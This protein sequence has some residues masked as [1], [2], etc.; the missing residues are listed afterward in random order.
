MANYATLKAAIAS[1]IKQNGNNEITGNL[2]QAQL[3][4]MINSLGA[5]YQYAGIATPAMNPGTPDPKVFY[6]ASTAG[7]YVNFGGLVLADGEIAILK[8]NGA[9]SKDSTGAASLEKLNQ[10]G[11]QTKFH[12]NI[13]LGYEDIRIHAQYNSSGEYAETEYR[14]LSDFIPVTYGDVILVDLDQGT[15]Q[16]SIAAFDSS[17]NIILQNSKTGL[18]SGYY[19]VPQ[20]V[21]FLRFGCFINTSPI[22]RK[23]E[24][25]DSLAICYSRTPII[26]NNNTKKLIIKSDLIV[27]QRG[28]SW[29]LQP[30][31]IPFEW[32]AA[33]SSLVRVVYDYDAQKIKFEY[34]TNNTSTYP[35][36]ATLFVLGTD[37]SNREVTFV[38]SSSV[39]TTI[40]GGTIIN[41]KTY[42]GEK[43]QTNF[44]ERGQ[45][46]TLQ[47]ARNHQSFASYNNIGVFVN[48]GV[49]INGNTDETAV[50]ASVHNLQTGALLG[51][52]LL[53]YG[54]N[55]IPH[56]NVVTFG[57]EFFSADSVLPLLYVSQWNGGKK[58][59]VYDITNNNNT[60][61]ATLVQ[62]ISTNGIPED[63]EGAGNRDWVVDS[64]RRLIFSIAYKANSD[65][66]SEGNG[67]K[68]MCFP[69]PE[70]SL[71]SVTFGSA[72]IL[73]SFEVDF[74]KFNQDKYCKFGKIFVLA[75]ME[76][77]QTDTKIVVIDTFLKKIST[78]I[79]IGIYWDREP[80]GLDCVNNNM[81]YTIGGAILYTING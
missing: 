35:I 20:N 39:P 1:A 73:D 41:R 50:V 57:N 80:E 44:F 10:L 4:S 12:S 51:R 8:Y 52:M 3:M 13:Q 71:E 46:V 81:V 40:V 55:T 66:I 34:W 58:C 23:V 27:K 43:L 6:I 60:Y 28:V 45:Y 32:T 69:L 49:D 7:T 70:K 68:I 26:F 62:T 42:Y 77:Y 14:R 65:R 22:V 29:L 72:N 67:T 9:W 21:S 5:G 2:L 54:Q 61:M 75:G 53:P 56:C 30:T 24:V 36:I 59:L 38:T 78:E 76:G 18:F 17:K 16:L 15:G 48:Y 74:I 19:V 33:Q 31:E 47:D 37:D 79:P 25:N 11:Q 63:I 64:E